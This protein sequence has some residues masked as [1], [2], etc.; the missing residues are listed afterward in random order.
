MGVKKNFRIITKNDA[1]DSEEGFPQK[2]DFRDDGT[3][4]ISFVKT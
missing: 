1:A 3:Q 4:K 2:I